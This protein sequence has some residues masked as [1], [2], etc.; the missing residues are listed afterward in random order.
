MINGA[1]FLV[2]S[3]YLEISNDIIT[4]SLAFIAFEIGGHLSKKNL[5]GL[6]KP[7]LWITL[8][9]S[10]VPIFLVAIGVGML[11]LFYNGFSTQDMIPIILPIVL[12]LGVL[13]APTDPN[14][15]LAIVHE[16][17]AKG[18][19]V[20]SIFG[21]AALDDI[22]GVFLFSITFAVSKILVVHSQLALAATIGGVL[23]NVCLSIIIAVVLALLIRLTCTLF[24]CW[25]KQIF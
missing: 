8:F 12:F 15:M 10:V 25:F 4:L 20:T 16:A 18:P 13:S 5:K 7:I 9:E 19:L 2:P 17:K 14:P 23:S 22:L 21:I 1:E 24:A 11:L 6:G 3:S